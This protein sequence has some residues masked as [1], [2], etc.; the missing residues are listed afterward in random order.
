MDTHQKTDAQTFC[1]KYAELAQPVTSG[2]IAPSTTAPWPNQIH[3][4]P[5]PSCGRCPTC[6]HSRWP[7][8]PQVT[9]T[10]PM[11]NGAGCLTAANPGLV[12]FYSSN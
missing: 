10:V 5:C 1:D 6:G 7:I 2:Y 12:P 9:W 4:Q 8:Y 11:M 3:P